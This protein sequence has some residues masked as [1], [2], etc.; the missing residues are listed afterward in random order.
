MFSLVKWL[1]VLL[2]CLGVI[3]FWRG[4]FS[5]SGPKPDVAGDKVNVNAPADKDLDA[6]GKPTANQRDKVNVVVSV[7][8]GKIKADVKKVK[9][10]IKEEVRVLE[11]KPKADRGE[12]GAALPLLGAHQS[13]AGGYHKAVERAK[14]CG[15]DC[16][17]IFTANPR[18]FSAER[19]GCTAYHAR[20]SPAVPCGPGRTGPEPPDR[21]RFV[22]D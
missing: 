18:S 5:L 19:K 7:D 3:G 22:S 1:F 9:E 11:G 8:K 20:R 2:L 17:Q 21:P 6:A 13:I 10:K 16:V 15:C 4:W 14:A 12:V